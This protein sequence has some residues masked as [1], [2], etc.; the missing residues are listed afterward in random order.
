MAKRGTLSPKIPADDLM[1]A[2]NYAASAM[3]SFSRRVMTPEILLY[4]FLKLPDVTAHG[5]LRQLA[6]QRGFNWASFENSITQAAQERLTA[7]V[8]FDF[9]SD[10]GERIPLGDDILYLIDE[11]NSLAKS[12]GETRSGT[13]QVLVFMPQQRVSASRLL[14]K[15]GITDDQGSSRAHRERP[16]R[17]CAQGVC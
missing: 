10:A 11:G 1:Q 4:A 6:E 8:N 3:K 7:D 17:C 9:E 2:L 14:T 13:E 12:R 5:L 16:D 15:Q